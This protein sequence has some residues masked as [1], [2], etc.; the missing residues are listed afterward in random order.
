M[1][2]SKP[3][4]NCPDAANKKAKNLFSRFTSETFDNDWGEGFGGIR[5]RGYYCI[6]ELAVLRVRGEMEAAFPNG[7]PYQPLIEDFGEV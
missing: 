7:I 2:F 5:A 6:H 4:C 1:A 3:I